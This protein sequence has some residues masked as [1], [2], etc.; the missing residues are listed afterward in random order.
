VFG[1]GSQPTKNR[2]RWPAGLSPQTVRLKLIRILSRAADPRFRR[3][4]RLGPAH[5]SHQRNR[6]S[7]PNGRCAELRPALCFVCTGWVRIRFQQRLMSR[8]I[9]TKQSQDL[10][11]EG[12]HW[13]RKRRSAATERGST[14]QQGSSRF[15]GGS[16]LSCLPTLALRCSSSQVRAATIARTQGQ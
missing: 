4:D 8:V 13:Q 11:R 1:C 12:C 9:R 10:P 7:A 14:T 15:R 6:P 16:A 5:L 2:F 3:M